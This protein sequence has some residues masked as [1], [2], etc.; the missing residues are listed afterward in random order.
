[1]KNFNNFFLFFLS[2]ESVECVSEFNRM[3]ECVLCCCFAV[4]FLFL[5]VL[6]FS[7]WD[8]ISCAHSYRP[9]SFHTHTFLAK[10]FFLCPLTDWIGSLFFLCAE[11]SFFF[12]I[13][14]TDCSSFSSSALARSLRHSLFLCQFICRYLFSLLFSFSL[15]LVCMRST[16]LCVCAFFRYFLHFCETQRTTK[17][18][19]FLFDIAL[20]SL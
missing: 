10:D 15:S 13:W 4:F 7:S 8:P 18:T 17:E 20:P 9:Q 2:L 12:L 5:F 11:R 1:M 19:F 6:I 16:Y 14:L 3:C